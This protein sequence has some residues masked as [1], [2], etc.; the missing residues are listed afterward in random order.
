[1]ENGLK[2]QLLAQSVKWKPMSRSVSIV[3]VMFVIT[4]I[5]PVARKGYEKEKP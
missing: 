4:A 2:A 5:Y 3:R 1:M